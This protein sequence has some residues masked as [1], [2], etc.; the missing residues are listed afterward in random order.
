LRDT[1][2]IT[3]RASLTGWFDTGST[4][5]NL[6]VARYHYRPALPTSQRLSER[7]E[8]MGYVGE[9]FLDEFSETDLNRHMVE[10]FSRFTTAM[11]L[12]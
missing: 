5:A 8:I 9:V 10:A 6:S 1:D 4:T 12:P 3:L 7:H 2:L 11:L